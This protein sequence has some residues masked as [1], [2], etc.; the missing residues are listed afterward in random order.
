MLPSSSSIG[1]SL[2]AYTK[3]DEI[4][5]SSNTWGLYCESK[6]SIFEVLQTFQKNTSFSVLFLFTCENEGHSLRILNDYAHLQ[7]FAQRDKS[8]SFFLIPRNPFRQNSTSVNCQR[9]TRGPNSELGSHSHSCKV[10]STPHLPRSEFKLAF[11]IMAFEPCP[12]NFQRHNALGPSFFPLFEFRPF[13]LP[14]SPLLSH[15]RHPFSNSYLRSH[16]FLLFPFFRLVGL[17]PLPPRF[18]LLSLWLFLFRFPAP[19]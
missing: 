7:A 4:R 19:N 16:S 15:F 3:H 1:C 12:S 9:N 11:C 14:P 2:G 10:A 5:L 18:S 17:F 6:T 13:P 8:F